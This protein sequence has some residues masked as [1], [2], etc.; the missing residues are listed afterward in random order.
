VITVSHDRYFLDKVATK[1]LAFEDGGVR[2]FFGNYTDYLDE[3]AFEADHS[4]LETKPAEVKVVKEKAERKRMSYFEKQEWATIED[5][6]AQLEQEIE[7]VSA[8]MATCGSDFGRL[9]DLQKALD[10]KNSQL[11]EKYERYEYLSEL[12]G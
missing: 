3:K 7:E 4:A 12:E 6:I 9:S 11:L 5:E 2:E 8:E 1:I 10:D